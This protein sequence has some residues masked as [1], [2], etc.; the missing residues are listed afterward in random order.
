MHIHA[1]DAGL[2]S[3]LRILSNANIHAFDGDTLEAVD[4]L[5]V[6]EGTDMKSYEVDLAGLVAGNEVVLVSI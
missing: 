5:L 4:A 3:F 2:L 1:S 6:D